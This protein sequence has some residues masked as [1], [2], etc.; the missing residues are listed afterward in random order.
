M[1]V[2]LVRFIIRFCYRLCGLVGFWN[3]LVRLR[4]Q[5]IGRLMFQ[6]VNRVMIIVIWVFWQLCRVLVVV[7]CRVLENWNS[8]ENMIS[9]VVM[10]IIVGFGEYIVVI[11]LCSNNIRFVEM[12]VQFS[13]VVIFMLV[14]KCVLC[15]RLVLR[16]WLICMVIVIFSEQGIMNISVLKFR[17]I[18]WLVI[19]FLLSLLISRVIIEKMFDL[20]NIVMLIGRLIVISG[21]MVV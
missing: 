1:I 9:E 19:M 11:C 10:V 18:W 8:V 6:Q 7:I 21:L 15:G 4:L 3:Q 5:F 13:V 2:V 14:V 12:Q 17:V 16:L 20:V